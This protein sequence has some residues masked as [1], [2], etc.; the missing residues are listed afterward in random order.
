MV[1]KS[2]NF[3]L[4]SKLPPKATMLKKLNNYYFF[5]KGKTEEGGKNHTPSIGNNQTL[6]CYIFYMPQLGLFF[7]FL[8][9]KVSETFALASA[10]PHT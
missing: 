2:A 6:N 5:L 3:A 4:F 1:Q 10:R 9:S 7:F 8:N